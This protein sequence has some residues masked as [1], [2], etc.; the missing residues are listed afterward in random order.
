MQK[1]RAQHLMVLAA[2]VA[3]LGIATPAYAG[4]QWSPV[5]EQKSESPEM[6]DEGD[7]VTPMPGTETDA[8]VATVDDVV[9]EALSE[10][11][12]TEADATASVDAAP[13]L[14]EAADIQADVVSGYGESLP[15]IIAL[16]QIVPAE[17]QFAFAEGVDLSTPVSWEGGQAWTD[18]LDEVMKSVS[19]RAEINEN[20]VSIGTAVAEELPMVAMDSTAP[21]ALESTDA[22]M[23]EDMPVMMAAPQEEYT[24]VASAVA[25]QPDGAAPEM[26]MMAPAW[27]GERGDLLRDLL[28]GWS[29]QAGVEL[30]WS[31]EYNYALEDTFQVSGSYE[32]AVRS[33]LDEF[34]DANPRPYGRLHEGN[35]EIPPVLVIETQ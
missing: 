5:A 29:Q 32:E 33:I 13:G 1:K 7:V 19:L 30:F 26:A 23:A 9:A 16:R 28:E 3:V 27:T 8:P 14:A 20:I 25:P 4:F 35:A 10:T 15:L 31:S 6:A 12:D 34:K 22:S 24:P 17:Y 18:L 11:A 21:M 2:T